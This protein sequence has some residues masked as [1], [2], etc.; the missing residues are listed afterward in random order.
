MRRFPLFFA[1]GEIV[2][3]R[4]DG[5]VLKYGRVENIS[6]TEGLDVLSIQFDPFEENFAVRV[7]YEDIYGRFPTQL[8]DHLYGLGTAKVGKTIALLS[9]CG[10]LMLR[11][12]S[13]LLTVQRRT[14]SDKS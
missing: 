11:F 7:N 6:A 4:C 1:D 2:I 14:S 5:G 3:V 13:D 12:I 10:R 9:E 8:E